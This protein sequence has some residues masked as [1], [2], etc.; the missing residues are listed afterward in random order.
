MSKSFPLPR[1]SVL[2]LGLMVALT[3]YANAEGPEGMPGGGAPR[4]TAVDVV[5][6]KPES[7]E[8]TT[9]LPGRTSAYRT[10]EVRPQVDGLIIERLFTEG[11]LVKSGEVLYKIDPA[12]YQVELDSAKASLASAQATLESSKLQEERYA[13]L[14]K[15]RA[16]S[17]QDYED[18]RATYRAAEANVMAAQA[19][20]SSAKINLAYTKIKAPISG[21]I[22]KST[23]TEGA[24]VTANQT[25]YL[26]TIQQLDPLFVDLAQSSSEVMKIRMSSKG[27][28][29]EFSGI[30]VT[31]DDGTEIEEKASLQF[32]DVTVDESTGTVGLR[33]LLP[34]PNH[35]YLPGLYVRADLPIEKREGAILV[36]QKALS[37]DSQGNAYVMVVNQEN[38]IESRSVVVDRIVGSDWLVNSGLQDGDT[39]V[40]SGLQ[41]IQVGSSVE[42]TVTT[43]E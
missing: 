5:Q 31:L 35:L 9:K 27:T 28:D 13:E 33:A 1:K 42:P 17:T 38:T 24:L 23:V 43:N 15:S 7:V 22:G 26:A 34:N 18:A 21:R 37:R 12:T 19:A 40:V 20:V 14:V 41:K 3:G 25:S 36:P 8:I 11:S 16:I 2:A 29:Q 10:A 6:L 32:A 30:K 39:V 4:A